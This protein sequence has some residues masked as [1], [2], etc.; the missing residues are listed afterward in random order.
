MK[1]GS[2]HARLAAALLA[3]LLATGTLNI[4][5]ILVTTHFHLRES[6]Q[7]TSFDLARNI[8]A[9]KI[10][11][12]MGPDGE[13]RSDGL[14]ELFHWMM[15]VNPELECYL[16][17]TDGTITAYDEESLGPLERDW[18]SLQPIREALSGP[19]HLPILGDDP[20]ELSRPEIF[21]VAPIPPEGPPRAYLYLLLA[22][23]PSAS[24]LENLRSS[25]ILRLS[26]FTGLLSLVVSL[27]AGALLFMLLTRP[28]RQLL[29]KMRSPQIQRITDLEPDA[30]RSL[31]RSGDEIATL[32]ST[33]VDLTRK[34]E[35]QIEHL[36][37]AAKLR[38]ELIANISHDL[39]T[40]IATLQGYLDT[41]TLKEDVLS[42]AER[43]EY[44]QI[45]QRQSA[46]LGKLVKELFELTRLERQEIEPQL[47][48]FRI[49]ELVQDNVHRFKL[50]AQQKGI[51]L[52]A[53]FDP[54]LPP[55]YA[56]VGLMERALENLIE[57]ALRFTPPGGT[58]SVELREVEQRLE[59]AVVDN[60]PG[61]REEDLP[62]I[63]DRT[64]RSRLQ[65]DPSHQGA[66]LGLAITRH[67][68]E[69]HAADLSVESKPGRGARFSLSLLIAPTTQQLSL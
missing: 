61:I 22:H 46:R 50:Q 56:D 51:D 55:V 62:R 15:V 58:I 64:Y 30:A 32:E 29:A 36:E 69:L 57:N 23:E 63:F 21:S 2:L 33:F 59:L 40:P 53:V 7:R 5:S 16:L 20:T 54:D 67:I 37:K 8:V 18:V 25:Y 35:A 3:V 4:V 11:Q 17:D 41:L 10:D 42:A 12:W 34:I 1:I 49:G 31:E 47:E 13:I 6:T 66:G 38:H 24:W 39:R 48:R 14:Q 27:A 68:A 60:G 28:L 52:R 26:A 19:D 43:E 65:G 44:L 9:M 45:A